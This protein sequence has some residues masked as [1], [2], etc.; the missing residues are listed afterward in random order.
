MPAG[1]PLLVK[2]RHAGEVL[3]QAAL[4]VRRTFRQ[5]LRAVLIGYLP[6]AVLLHL[7]MVPGSQRIAAGLIPT[8]P[9]IQQQLV[10]MCVWMLGDVVLLRQFARG[11]LLS[12]TGADLRGLSITQRRA[13]LGGLKRLPAAATATLLTYGPFGVILLLLT[14]LAAQDETLLLVV[15]IVA[16]LCFLA[17]LPLAVFGYNSV[18]VAVLERRGAFSALARSFRL[19]A[20]AVGTLFLVVAVQFI[21]R[22]FAGLMPVLMPNLWIQSIVYSISLGL[23]M[24]FDAAVESVLYFTLRCEREN[25]DLDLQAREVELFG[26]EE[27]ETRTAAYDQFSFRPAVMKD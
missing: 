17:G 8:V 14:A 19:G 5:S 15:I 3:D 20:A 7:P 23:L 11:W 26:A 12:I 18:A 25:Y 2:P 16:P 21:V 4:S 9:E 24:I 6:W 13:A 22:M 27:L 1:D 10:W